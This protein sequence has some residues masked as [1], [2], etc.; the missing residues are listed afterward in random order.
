[1]L[2]HEFTESVYESV[3]ENVKTIYVVDMYI[4]KLLTG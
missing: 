1:M 4:D 3:N 2:G